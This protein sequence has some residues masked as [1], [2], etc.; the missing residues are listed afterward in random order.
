MEQRRHRRY[1]VSLP[2]EVGFNAAGTQT[3][4][5]SSRDIS[6]KGVYFVVSPGFELGSE[7]EFDIALPRGFCQGQRVQI[8]CSGKIIRLEPFEQPGRFGVAAIIK[9]YQFTRLG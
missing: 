8:H 9:N 1:R 6:A 7:L 3:I 2:L 4:E 5:T